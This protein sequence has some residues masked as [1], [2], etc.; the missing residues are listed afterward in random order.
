MVFGGD[1]FKTQRPA[2][3]QVHE[4]WR[5]PAPLYEIAMG[6][7]D[8]LGILGY[9][10]AAYELREQLLE[11]GALPP[12]RIYVP[13]GTMGTV[14]GLALGLK[15]A[16][17]DTTVVAVRV[18]NFTVAGPERARSLIDDTLAWLAEIDPSI[19]PPVD[20]VSAIEFRDDQFGEGYAIPTEAG[21][22]AG[23]LARDLAEIELDQ[24]YSAKA[25]AA[26]VADARAGRLESER[27]MFWNTYNSAPYPD[28]LAD[29]DTS[30]VPEPLRYCLDG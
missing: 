23:E 24:T 5:G 14:I 10:L 15:M 16:G 7:T 26:L 27:A 2:A 29:V 25:F 18:V 6:G 21:E 19:A 4:Q 8:R 13:C 11:K 30:A 9:L 28:D 12:T 22:E 1:S 20:V 3:A 17:L